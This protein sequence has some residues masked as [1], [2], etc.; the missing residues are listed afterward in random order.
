MYRNDTLAGKRLYFGLSVLLPV[1]DIIVVADTQ[2]PAGENDS[3]DI[4]IEAG[5]SDSFL[6]GLGSTS[7][8]GENET[9]ADPDG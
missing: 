1:L 8:L 2:R 4:V 5:G 7:F 3:A 9:S 6:V